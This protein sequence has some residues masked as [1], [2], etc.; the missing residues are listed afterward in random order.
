[1]C[2][3][4]TTIDIPETLLRRAKAAAALEGKTLKDFFTQALEQRLRP[5]AD[6]HRGERVALPL[7]P[8]RAPG[9]RELTGDDLAHALEAEDVDALT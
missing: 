3:M 7:V 9:G 8:S 2:V 4:R 5:G 6:E 1:M